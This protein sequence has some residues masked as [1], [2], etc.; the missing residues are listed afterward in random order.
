MSRY[1]LHLAVALII[2]AMVLPG[3]S[4]IVDTPS[5]S[6]E[7]TTATYGR[8]G[9]SGT[10]ILLNGEVTSQKFFGVVETTALQNAILAYIEGETG[11]AGKTS[12]LNGPDTSNKGYIPYH[13]TAEQFWHQYFAI[14]EYYDCNLVRL[15]A[16]DAW[17]SRIQYQAWLN[18]HD[19]YISMLKLICAQAEQHGV[20]LCFV[21]AGSQEY[22]TYAYGGSGSVFNTSSTAYARYIAYVRDTMM[23]LE[24]EDAIAMYDLFNEPDHDNCYTNYWS[25]SGGKTGFNTWSKAVA[26]ATA[27]YSTHP[28]TMGIAGLGKM[29]GWGLADFKLATG[30]C[31]FE[32]LHRH[33]YASASGASNAY[34]FNDP[35]AWADACGRPLYWGELGYNG[36]YPL[37]RWAFGEQTIWAAGGQMIGTM[38]LTGTAGYPYT[39]G[40]L[41]DPEVKRDPLPE[42]EFTSI[43]VTNATVNDTYSYQVNTSVASTLSISTDAAF[44]SISSSGLISGIPDA[45]GL[46]NVS[47]LASASEGRRAYQNFTLEVPEPPAPTVVP[48]EDDVEEPDAETIENE[49][50]EVPTNTTEEAPSD[51]TD[52][53]PSNDNEE[54]PQNTTDPATNASP[55]TVTDQNGSA[56]NSTTNSNVNVTSDRSSWA[57]ILS[58]LQSR[59]NWR[60]M[61]SQGTEANTSSS[62]NMTIAGSADKGIIKA[63]EA[64][65]VLAVTAAM[66][67]TTIALLAVWKF[68]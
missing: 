8:I 31:G 39:G 42:I 57:E 43:P 47:I 48:V 9:V 46:Y 2:A 11:V 20:W 35:E 54:P 52:G 65:M 10:N 22:P 6:A 18:H 27:G 38:V 61:F 7:T 64:T 62:E 50:E 49:A 33:Y 59:L 21:M 19:E 30:T 5:A 41:P 24:G 36:V 29:F 40:L 37:T 3:F 34:L 17:G 68:R 32:I 25:T 14:T 1:K 58:K 63:D 45:H 67:T 4:V 15:G 51:N 12:H 23:A 55:H 56:G 66:V 16:G 26:S 53:M 60:S 28:R 44:L 13:E